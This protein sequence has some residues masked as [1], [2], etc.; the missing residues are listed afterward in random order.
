MRFEVW[1]R[2]VASVIQEGFVLREVGSP[3]VWVIVAGAKFHI[4]SANILRSFYGGWPNVIVTRGGHLNGV[5]RIPADGTLLREHGRPEVYVIQG[6]VKRH[7]TR[8]DLLKPFGG[9]TAVRLVPP[10]SLDA[11]PNGPSV[12]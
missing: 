1:P 9:W 2:D 11:I 5:S 3:E 7:V 4:V 12:V 8:G 10:G 6:Q